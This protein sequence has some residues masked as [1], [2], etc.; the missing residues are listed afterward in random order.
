PSL[1]IHQLPHTSCDVAEYLREYGA[2]TNMIGLARGFGKRIA[3]LNVEERDVINEHD[4]AVFV[5]GNFET[6]ID[7]KFPALRR[8]IHVPIVVVAGPSREDLVKTIQPPIEGYV[9]GVGR[10]MHRLK[11]PEEIEKLEEIVS[12]VAR[13]LDT[14]REEIAKDPLSVLPPHLMDVIMDKL[15]AIHEVTHPTPVTVQMAGLRVKLPYDPYAEEVKKLEIE[16]GV[17][18]GDVADLSPSRMRDYIL[19]KVRPFSET[20]IMV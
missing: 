16:N 6:C 18:V 2:K 14:K 20:N 15:P 8:G 5:L 10:V 9:G 19:L 11:R 7:Y 3:Q 1:E 4:A 17:K 12:E 13:V